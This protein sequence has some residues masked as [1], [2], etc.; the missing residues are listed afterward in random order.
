VSFTA[1]PNG[2]R[3]LGFNLSEFEDTLDLFDA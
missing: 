2:W 3:R 1:T